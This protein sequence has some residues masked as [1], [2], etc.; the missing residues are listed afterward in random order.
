MNIKEKQDFNY[1]RDQ[2][3]A[4]HKEKKAIEDRYKNSTKIKEEA[5]Q[6]QSIKDFLMMQI[7]EAVTQLKNI[8]EEFKILQYKAS[9]EKDPEQKQKH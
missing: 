7:Y 5:D 4:N 1:P 8:S 2:V 3:I 6:R 9:I